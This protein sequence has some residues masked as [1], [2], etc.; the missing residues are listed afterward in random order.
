MSYPANTAPED[1][2]RRL[3]TAI[4]PTVYV[5]GKPYTWDELI[6]S[7]IRKTNLDRF[8]ADTSELI[9]QRRAMIAKVLPA[10]VKPI[11][12]AQNYKAFRG[13]HEQ[14]KT[15]ALGVYTSVFGIPFTPMNPGSDGGLDTL[16]LYQKVDY[17]APAP[18]QASARGVAVTTTS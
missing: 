10:A 13:S 4:S 12:R 5:Q 14:T 8:I 6:E 1:V 2:A 18:V 9:K 7:A 3:F 16:N 11:L 15:G 17:E